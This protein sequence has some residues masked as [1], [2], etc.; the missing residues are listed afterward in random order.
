MNNFWEGSKSS[1]AIIIGS[2]IIG[3]FV[4]LGLSEN[5]K[6]VIPA[7]AGIQ[8][9]SSPSTPR[10]DGGAK[11]SSQISQGL[12]QSCGADE[13]TIV[14]KVIDGDT[15]VVEGGYHV[16]LIGVD[17]DENGYPCYEQA[18][19]RLEELVL[20]R[21][22]KLEKDKT[23]VDQYGRCLRYMFLG[24]TNINVQLAKE[25]VA[26]ARFYQPDVK[27]RTEIAEAEKQARASGMGCKWEGVSK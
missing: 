22:V 9:A 20:G 4:Y 7:K 27:Y 19:A 12:A 10:N 25:G 6:V 16:R 1:V 23:D 26:V 3:F 13:N 21:M 15:V 14:T 17:A 24:I 5:K 18:K 8:I 2:I 11:I